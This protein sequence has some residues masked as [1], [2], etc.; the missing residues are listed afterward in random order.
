MKLRHWIKRPKEETLQ[1]SSTNQATGCHFK[2]TPLV[3]S[4]LEIPS[5]RGKRYHIFL[6]SC[7]EKLEW[8]NI[9]SENPISF[10]IFQNPSKTLPSP[11]MKDETNPLDRI[12]LSQLILLIPGGRPGALYLCENTRSGC[13]KCSYGY[14][15]S[16]DWTHH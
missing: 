1:R 14:H 13:M 16:Q 15:D 6:Y 5:N 3:G 7:I 2:L 9:A 10:R 4:F 12:D 11:S 8:N